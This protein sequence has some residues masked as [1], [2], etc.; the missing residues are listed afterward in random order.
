ML[1]HRRPIR[2]VDGL[3]KRSTKRS[4]LAL[5]EFASKLASNNQTSFI[6]PALVTGVL[7]LLLRPNHHFHPLDFRP[8][9][10]SPNI[11]VTL[12]RF[13]LR[14]VRFRTT[15]AQAWSNFFQMKLIGSIR[16]VCSINAQ[17]GT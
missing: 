13:F 12:F 14:I 1:A 16:M 9:S 3:T 5:P 8:C 17:Y 4:P 10:L 15:S 2:M 6:K 7:R 11:I